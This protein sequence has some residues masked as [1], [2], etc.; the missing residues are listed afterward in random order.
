MQ[1][2]SQE[3]EEKGR[4]LAAEQTHWFVTDYI[5]KISESAQMG[6]TLSAP[7]LDAIEEFLAGFR[8]LA[9]SEFLRWFRISRWIQK[10]L[11]IQKFSLDSEDSL[12]E[13]APTTTVAVTRSLRY[14]AARSSDPTRQLLGHGTRTPQRGV[15][16]MGCHYGDTCP[17]MA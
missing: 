15:L 9:D 12:L 13:I 1:E 2:A 5:S 11:L 16:G 6:E 17:R 14:H 7:E 4:T 8:R 10:I 3:A